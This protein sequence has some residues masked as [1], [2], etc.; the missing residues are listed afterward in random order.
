MRYSEKL[1]NFIN[2]NQPKSVEIDLDILKKDERFEFKIDKGMI[3]IKFTSKDREYHIS[4]PFT[5]R[6][7]FDFRQEIEE[8][9]VRYI[10]NPQGFS[11][12]STVVY[13]AIKEILGVDTVKKDFNEKVGAIASPSWLDLE[14]PPRLV[15]MFHS[16]R[17][18]M[19]DDFV[20]RER[21]RWKR[22]DE[23]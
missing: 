2:D 9:F 18:K 23:S 1:Q 21:S 8:E 13:E 22:R 7:Y 5:T 17:E 20:R 15:L 12:H 11:Q 16:E 6:R 4:S 10:P 14:Y 3:W 19:L